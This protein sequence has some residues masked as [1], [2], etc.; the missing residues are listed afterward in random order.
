[1]SWSNFDEGRRFGLEAE[2]PAAQGAVVAKALERLAGELPLMPEEDRKWSAPARRADA[3]VALC[4]ERIASD[5]DPDR[6]TVVVHAS[7]ESLMSGE[8]NAET[9]DGG[10]IPSQTARRLA[11]NARVQVVVEDPGGQVVRLGRIMREPPA[12]MVRQLRYLDRECRFPGCGSR[13]FTQAHHVTWWEKGGRTDLENLVL[14]CSFH[15]KLVHEYGWRLIR[16]RDGIVR[17][18]HPDGTRYRA[19]PGPRAGPDPPRDTPIER[20][21]G[22]IAA[23]F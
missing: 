9:E 15:H 8:G 2:L 10:V 12:W 5:P 13:R 23:G 18:F 19:G 3:L 6:A 14:I 21:F 4:S 11:C 22:L 1:V 7:L 17:W 16:E 20:D